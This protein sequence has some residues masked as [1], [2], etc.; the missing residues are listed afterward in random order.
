VNES[1]RTTQRV[2]IHPIFQYGGQLV[3]VSAEKNG[4]DGKA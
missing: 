4:I 2:Q 1:A 3:Q